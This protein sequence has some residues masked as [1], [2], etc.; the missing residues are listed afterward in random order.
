LGESGV[1]RD[2]SYNVTVILPFVESQNELLNGAKIP[3]R[4]D[5]PG[6][7]A[8]ANGTMRKRDDGGIEIEW[9]FEFMP[10]GEGTGEDD[11]ANWRME[12]NFR[13]RN[14][15]EHPDFLKLKAKY[16]WDEKEQ[17]FPEEMPGSDGG[18][19]FSKGDEGKKSPMF[20]RA[21]FDDLGA[22]LIHT[23]YA[24][25]LGN[26]WKAMYTINKQPC[27][28]IPIVPGRDWLGLVP[29]WGCCGDGFQ[30]T[31]EWMLSNVG[32]FPKDIYLALQK[33]GL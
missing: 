24:K 30:I 6:Y 9:V 18:R 31:Q 25:K 23:Y 12:G 27:K 4:P 5:L 21:S 15:Q 19:G 11:K 13:Q 28:F 14:I 29:K 17:K 8:P 20:G 7:P 10:P 32:G 26:L 33:G 3:H 16:G 22:T 1:N 2:G